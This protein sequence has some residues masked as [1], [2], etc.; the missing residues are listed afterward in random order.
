MVAKQSGAGAPAG[1]SPAELAFQN[2]QAQMQA[3]MAGQT[4]RVAEMEARLAA[5]QAM[6]SG[7]SPATSAAEQPPAVWAV[8]LWMFK[9]VGDGRPLLDETGVALGDLRAKLETAWNIIAGLDPKAGQQCTL[10]VWTPPL[11]A[12]QQ[13]DGK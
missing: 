5:M 7:Q 11:V 2:Y 13:K 1:A 10:V 8:Q 6:L 12:G 9:Q 3:M 4:Q